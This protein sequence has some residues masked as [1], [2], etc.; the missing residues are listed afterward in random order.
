MPRS[1]P[2]AL[3][4]SHR[5]LGVLIKLN[6]LMGFLILGLLVAS[7]LAEGYVFKALGVHR[8][9]DNATLVRGMRLIMLLGIAAVPLTHLVLSRLL[10]IVETVRVGDPFISIN[11]ERLQR[12]AWAVEG[13]RMRDDL[14]GTV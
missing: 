14:E 5:V 8:V 4:L 12:I 1:Y 6:L 2:D 7:I 3:A 10:A 9:E 13:A 11:A